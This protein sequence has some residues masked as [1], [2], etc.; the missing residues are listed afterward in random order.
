M[1][2]DRTLN[3]SAK[4][5]VHGGLSLYLI[6]FYVNGVW[7]LGGLTLFTYD[8]DI[9]YFTSNISPSQEKVTPTAFSKCTLRDARPI[10]SFEPL[11][12]SFNNFAFD[13]KRNGHCRHKHTA[14]IPIPV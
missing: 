11:A 13:R 3:I 14:A 4:L 6:H 8:E 5:T 9:R 7:N 1:M 12:T 10:D 2:E